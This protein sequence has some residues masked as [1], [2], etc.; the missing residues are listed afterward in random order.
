MIVDLT[1]TTADHEVEARS[2][3][4]KHF[5]TNRLV[6]DI[7]N[8][9]DASSVRRAFFADDIPDDI[10]YGAEYER[11]PTSR[12]AYFYKGKVVP[13]LDETMIPVPHK[14]AVIYS[15]KSAS[16]SIPADI[17]QQLIEQEWDIMCQ[18][19]MACVQKE[20]V[21]YPFGSKEFCHH[22][23]KKLARTGQK[24]DVMLVNPADACKFPSLF[25]TVECSLVPRNS[26]FLLPPRNY[27]GC[28]SAILHVTATQSGQFDGL[29]WTEA[30]YS[31][32]YGEQAGWFFSER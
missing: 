30:G 13:V 24:A 3:Q 32:I 25:K 16:S 5:Q 20:I 29:F 11:D 10:P 23:F 31:I 14:N 17:A 18:L 12:S 21:E 4:K 26:I 15:F 28:I 2:L 7:Q 9:L 6:G 27:A 8:L 22:S 1:Q 19:L